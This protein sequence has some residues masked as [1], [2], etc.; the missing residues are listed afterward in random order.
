[1]PILPFSI[2]TYS[3]NPV[4]LQ[5][6]QTINLP[7]SPGFSA[8]SYSLSGVL[9][10]G[11]S[12]NTTTGYFTGTATTLTPATTLTVTATQAN[13]STSTCAL[14]ISVVDIPVPAVQANMNSA[15]ARTDNVLLQEQ[16]FLQCAE[17][18][19]NN[20]GVLGRDSATFELQNLVSFRWVYFYFSRLGFT[21]QN[22]TATNDD[23]GFVSYFGALPSWPGPAEGPFG[24]WF[25]GYPYSDFTQYPIGV[26][27]HPIRRVRIS[28]SQY[29]NYWSFPYTP[30]L[31]GYPF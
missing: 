31:G 1:M 6:G 26:K 21:V 25:D 29:T 19:I 11:I 22:L 15:T 17:Q 3:F 23:L 10:A 4:F 18:M 7:P 24:P 16:N 5:P 30:F 27:S 28:W 2:L 14:I 8:V 9:P 13:S 12:F 20:N